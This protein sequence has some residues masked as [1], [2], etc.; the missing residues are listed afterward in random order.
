MDLIVAL[1]EHGRYQEVMELYEKLVAESRQIF[2]P[3]H[4]DTQNYENLI[5]IDKK[6]LQFGIPIASNSSPAGA[7]TSQKKEVWAVMDC[8]QQPAI[9]R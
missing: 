2:G 5:V 8:E 7:A 3:D 1:D 9:T 4:P 6:R